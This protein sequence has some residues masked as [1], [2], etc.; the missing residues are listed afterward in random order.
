MDSPGELWLPQQSAGVSVLVCDT[1]Q[2]HLPASATEALRCHYIALSH[3]IQISDTVRNDNKSDPL[4]H[5]DGIVDS[6]C[7]K[8]E[9][10]TDSNVPFTIICPT[11]YETDAKFYSMYQYLQNGTLT[12][13]V[14]KDKPILIMEDK[15]IIG[16][17]G[18]LYR[19]DIP[20]QKHFAGLKPTT[21][22]LCVPLCH[23]MISYVHDNCG[24]YAAQS[25]FH[26]LAARYFWKSMFADAVEYFK[27]CDTC[28]RT[29]INYGHR[30]APLHLLLV[31][32]EIGTKFSMDH[33]VL[34][35]TTAAGNTAVLVIVECF[36]GFSHLIPVLGQT[37]D[38]TARAIVQHIVPIWGCNCHYIV[39]RHLLC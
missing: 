28:Q 39:I 3:D 6:N 22:R 26:T 35:R 20:Y 19:V 34:T 18:L 13:N 14:K 11:D 32:E 7:T 33:K 25:L 21:K 23:D 38:T 9:T 24:H 30:Y 36:S 37:A 2:S 15:Y 5:S 31:P 29:K 8:D 17:D 16:E 27:T 1:H 12:G 4:I 10:G